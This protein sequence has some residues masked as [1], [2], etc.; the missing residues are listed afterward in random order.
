MDSKT[1]DI[2][3]SSLLSQLKAGDRAAF[4]TVYNKFMKKLYRYSLRF[5]HS[6]DIAEEVVQTAFIRLWEYRHNIDVEKPLDAYLYVITRNAALDFLRKAAVDEKMKKEIW[7]N[8]SPIAGN[9]EADFVYS[10]YKAIAEK[11]IVQLSPVRKKV[12]NMRY[13]EEMSYDEIARQLNISKN[14]VKTH[15]LKATH[16]VKEY[17]RL[18]T[19]IILATIIFVWI[20]I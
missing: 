2:N 3:E 10:Q 8:Y 6:E 4:F 18:N 1:T 16:F 11:A 5:V 20:V 7:L 14:T 19:D 13:T 17:L 9:P 15:L 12:F